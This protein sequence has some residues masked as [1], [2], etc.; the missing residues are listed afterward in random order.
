MGRMTRSIAPLLLAIAGCGGEH[1][2]AGS[3]ATFAAREPFDPATLAA[4]EVFAWGSQPIAVSPPPD[5]W[6]MERE[7]SGGLRGVRFIKSQSFGEEIRIAEYYALDDRLRCTEQLDLLERLDEMNRNE[8]SRA[9][10]RA[11]FY[12]PKPYTSF[13]ARAAEVANEAFDE[14]RAAYLA[15]DVSGARYAIRRAIDRGRS[16]RYSLE[17]VLDEVLFDRAA[18]EPFGTVETMPPESGYVGGMPSVSV[19]YTL[20]STANGHLYFGRQVY[21]MQDSRL[22]VLSFHGLRHHI[23][24]F[25]AIVDSV[26]FPSSRCVL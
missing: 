3:E 16:I 12:V 11:R 23:E 26:T 14:A 6:Y 1:D 25:E 7:S 20:D 21:V 5:G 13:E 15:G 18:Y 2:T 24:L 10:Q 22:F 17:D 9:L 4:P 8:F 19:D